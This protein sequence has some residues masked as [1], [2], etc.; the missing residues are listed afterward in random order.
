MAYNLAAAVVLQSEPRAGT[1]HARWRRV[2]RG[3]VERSAMQKATAIS[4]KNIRFI[5]VRE[6]AREITIGIPTHGACR[7]LARRDAVPRSAVRRYGALGGRRRRD[8]IGV[9]AG[10]PPPRA[11]PGGSRLAAARARA[12]R[13][14]SVFSFTFCEILSMLLSRDC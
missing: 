4:F 2:G 12:E 13:S 3:V 1:G 6:T 11:G 9:G 14:E 10:P 8:P 5:S 7:A